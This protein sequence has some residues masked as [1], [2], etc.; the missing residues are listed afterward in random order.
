MK[1]GYWKWLIGGLTKFGLDFLRC[2]PVVIFK[3]I[4]EMFKAGYDFLKEELRKSATWENIFAATGSIFIISLLFWVLAWVIPETKSLA[5]F[6][7]GIGELGLFLVLTYA[8]WRSE[9]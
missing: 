9:Q 3:I 5:M 4:P 2:V 1:S 6:W 7:W 8:Y